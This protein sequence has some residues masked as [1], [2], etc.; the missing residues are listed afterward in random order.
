MEQAGSAGNAF[1]VRIIGEYAK[2]WA[3]RMVYPMCVV[4]ASANEQVGG[5]GANASLRVARD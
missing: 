5:S 2:A 4:G 3:G 1:V